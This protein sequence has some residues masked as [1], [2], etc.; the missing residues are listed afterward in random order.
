MSRLHLRTRRT[1][2]LI[3]TAI[4]I[5]I[6]YLAAWME[7][8]RLGH[9]SFLTGMTCLSAL[10][11][12]IMFGVRRRIPILPLGSASTWTQIHIYT[13]L[14]ATAVY[15]MHVPALIGA[16]IFECVL[17]ILFW[18]VSAS[19]CYGIYASRTLPKRLTA[20]KGQYRFD[21]IVWHRHQIAD[22]AAQ[23][24]EHVAERST[25]R[26]LG[27][28]YTTCLKPFFSNRPSVAYVLLP[29][30]NRRRHLLSGLQELDRYLED[31][32]RETAGRFAALVRRRD[33]LDY[34]FALQLRLRL[35]LL[36]HSALSVGLL[37]AAIVH[38]IVAWRFTSG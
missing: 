20:V 8:S 23:L 6:V 32:G 37:A 7:D 12:L 26:V 35:W 4:A 24:L 9:A 15:I 21:R 1:I 10:I 31:E 3:A 27:T 18:I 29:T 38:A 22:V 28:Y 17:S 19:G 2:A 34:Q 30:G 5:L 33:D 25:L 11:L 14:F 16:G 36:V 13:G